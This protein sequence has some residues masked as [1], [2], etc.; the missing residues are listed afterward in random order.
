MNIQNGIILL[1]KIGRKVAPT[2]FAVAGGVGVVAT[3]VTA[4]KAGLRYQE[5]KNKK[6][7][8]K[9]VVTGVATIA[10]IFTGDRLHAKRYAALAGAASVVE[11]NFRDYRDIYAPDVDNV[12]RNEVNEKRAEDIWKRCQQNGIK[13]VDTHTGNDL[14]FEPE[15]MTWFLASEGHVKDAAYHTN[16][17]FKL[18]GSEPFNEWLKFLGLPDDD[19]SFEMLGWYDYEGEAYYGYTWIDF[20]LKPKELRD[21]TKY[22]EIFYPFG[23]HLTEK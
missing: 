2:A 22:T 7:F 8:I 10:C 23:P 12:A 11:R 3:G 21:G 17:N 6:V 15:S 14:W 9:P 5:T 19:L 1:G 20:E 18:R 4:A 16:R 13:P